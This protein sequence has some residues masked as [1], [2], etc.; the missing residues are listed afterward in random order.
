MCSSGS[1]RGAMFRTI[2]SLPPASIFF[3]LI[4]IAGT[5]LVIAIT[6][7]SPYVVLGL[8]SL[9]IL[10]SFL[11]TVTRF[12]EISFL[13]RVAFLLLSL[14][15]FLLLLLPIA[16]TVFHYLLAPPDPC[17][18]VPPFLPVFCSGKQAFNYY[19]TI[20]MMTLAGLVA[21][22]GT[23]LYPITVKG[24]LVSV[25]LLATATGLFLFTVLPTQLPL[26]VTL[27]LIPVTAGAALVVVSWIAPKSG[28]SLPHLYGQ[29]VRVFTQHVTLI[30]ILA[31]VLLGAI[32]GLWGYANETVA[33]LE[34]TCAT[35]PPSP[36]GL[37]E[38]LGL[39]NPTN[40][41]V[42]VV[43]KTTYNYTGA[44]LIRAQAESLIPAHATGYLIL[45]VSFPPV[46]ATYPL[47]ITYERHYTTLLWAFTQQG[48]DIDSGS[49][50]HPNL[51]LPPC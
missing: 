28:G 2:A 29:T 17:L 21:V 35:F 26:A 41:P 3:L 51:E 4:T 38:T 33:S 20:N 27:V 25:P 6:P 42:Y 43:W 13:E 50:T 19:S 48:V 49:R 12:S 14:G 46:N 40:A 1:E 23:L 22:L 44:P 18:N 31:I 37:N 15:A 10:F 47:M 36:Q 32:S 9:A 11:L 16:I 24:Y 34:L 45:I 8:A 5:L 30:I 39:T 7:S